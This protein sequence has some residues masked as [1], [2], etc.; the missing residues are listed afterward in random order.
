MSGSIGGS[1]IPT[2]AVRPT[3][4]EY[5]EKVLK[6][7]PGY[8]SCD[9][10]G[11]YNV[12]MQLGQEKK[13]GHGDID[14]A[15]HIEADDIKKMKKDFKAYCEKLPDDVTVPF[16]D[17]KRKGD[18]AQLFG[19]IVTIGFPIVGDEEH[20]VQIDNIL[21]TSDK[22]KVFQK[23]FLDMNAQ[24]QALFQGLVRVLLQHEDQNAIWKHFGFEGFPEPAKDQEYEFVL[25]IAGL[26]LRLVTLTPDRREAGRVEMWRSNDWEDVKWLMRDYEFEG[27]YND[28]LEATAKR[29]TDERSRSRIVGIIKSMI[30]VGPGEVGTPKGDA[31]EAFIKLAEE[32]LKVSA[33]ESKV[34]LSEYVDILENAI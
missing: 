25:S 14:L 11:S 22:D 31:K 12:I 7:F 28:A 15:V 19:A 10:T 9:T 16:K 26:S 34:S 2:K 6:G 30:R 20:Y 3:V 27:D 1:R 29:I 17:G 23:S 18:K 8:K 33:K 32:T 13:E 21:V 5:I 24:K 4:D